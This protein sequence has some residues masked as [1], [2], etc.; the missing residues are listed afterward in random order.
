MFDLTLH[1]QSPVMGGGHLGEGVGKDQAT[2]AQRTKSSACSQ[3]IQTYKTSFFGVSFLMKGFFCIDK[4][5]FSPG[6]PR[7]GDSNAS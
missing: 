2:M 7:T 1:Q 3:G 6:H 4:D 5:T